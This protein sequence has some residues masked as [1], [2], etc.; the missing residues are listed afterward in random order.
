MKFEC[1]AAWQ[2]REKE[3]KTGQLKEAVYTFGMRENEAAKM[4]YLEQELQHQQFEFSIQDRAFHLLDQLQHRKE[5]HRD[6]FAKFEERVNVVQR[7]R[8]QHAH[9]REATLQK[10][11]DAKRE[12]AEQEK[13]TT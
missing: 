12:V 13:V 6:K 11:A 3:L 9:L 8:W 4:R 10:S 1:R 5:L 7:E 2:I